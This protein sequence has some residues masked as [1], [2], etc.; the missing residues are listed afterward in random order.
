M[1]QDILKSIG[2]NNSKAPDDDT[3]TPNTQAEQGLGGFLQGISGAGLGGTATA[4]AFYFP[5]ELIGGVAPRVLGQE[6]EISWNAAAEACDSE[7]IHLIW[8]ATEDRVWYVASRASD[9]AAHPHTWCPFASLLPG[10]AGTEEPPVCYT[11]YSDEAATMMTITKD[12]IQIHRGTSS[13]VRAK[14]ERVA[15]ELGGAKMIELTPQKIAS[16]VPQA[17]Q[18]LSLLEDRAR[19]MLAAIVVMSGV[20]VTTIAFVVWLL[21]GMALLTARA[22]TAAAKERSAQKSQDLLLLVQKM[23]T[24]DLRQQI[25]K[26]SDLNEDLVQVGGWLKL[27]ELKA[28]VIRWKALVPTSITGDRIK[29][30]GGMT[31]ETTDQGVL[32]GNEAAMQAIRQQKDKQ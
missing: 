28:G 5:P 6:R 26:F 8:S 20:M 23:R 7:R 19:R 1:L 21:A 30:L 2:G 16:L 3:A 31:I 32:I 24:S 27:Y 17:W 14:A 13:V 25:S 11:Y 12:L 22:E 18:S 29:E 10:M 9:L 15:R 4:A